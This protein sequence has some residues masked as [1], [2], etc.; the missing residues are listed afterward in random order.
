MISKVTLSAA[1]LAAALFAATLPGS[2]TTVGNLAPLKGITAGQQ[3][4]VEET[5]G[6]HRKCWRGLNGWH[7]HV[8]GVG[9]VQCTNKKCTYELFGPTKCVYF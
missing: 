5:H 6:W 9:R 8:R 1:A 7:K 3:S 4:M 2:A